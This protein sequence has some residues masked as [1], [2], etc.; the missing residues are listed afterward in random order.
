MSVRVLA[1]CKFAEETA[2]EF[3]FAKGAPIVRAVALA[4]LV[5]KA[6]LPSQGYNRRA[7]TR[8]WEYNSAVRS[9][10]QQLL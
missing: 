10:S 4:I 1:A 9:A 3:E 7:Y 8:Y 2:F 5:S 6:H